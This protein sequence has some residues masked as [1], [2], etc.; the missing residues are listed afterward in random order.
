VGDAGD[1]PI[2]SYTVDRT[3]SDLGRVG[4]AVIVIDVVLLTLF[5]RS[6][7]A[8][9]Y[10]VAASVLALAA[11]VGATT[12]FFRLLPGPADLTS[13]VPFAAA[14]LLSASPATAACARPTW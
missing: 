6:F 14:V 2:A 4:V 10:L 9:L 7:G 5:P 13:Y 11:A 8:P 3:V 12:Y 1:T